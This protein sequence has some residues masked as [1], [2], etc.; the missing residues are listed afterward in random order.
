[1]GSFG[2]WAPKDG[3]QTVPQKLVVESICLIMVDVFSGC[4]F[5][6]LVVVFLAALVVLVVLAR[7]SQ[8]K[9]FWF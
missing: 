7:S 8:L 6:G 4:L 2:F 5:A 1:M 3:F 9:R